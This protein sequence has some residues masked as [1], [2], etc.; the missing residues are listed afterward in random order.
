MTE[1]SADLK[2]ELKQLKKELKDLKQ[3]NKDLERLINSKSF[4]VSKKLATVFNNSFPLESKRREIILYAGKG[5]LS[6]S[7]KYQNRK[8]IAAQKSLRKVV[9]NNPVIIYDSIPWDVDLRQRPQHLAQQ[10]SRFNFFVVYLERGGTKTLRKVNDRLYTINHTSVLDG[11]K[12]TNGRK[13]FLASS[14]NVHSE[15]YE[16]VK[17]TFENNFG[18]IYEYIDD[19]SDDISPNVYELQMFYDSVKEHKPLLTLASSKKLR[20]NL[21]DDGFSEDNILLSENAAN[22]EH[23]DYTKIV[24]TVP[25]DLKKVLDTNRPVVGFYGAIAPWLDGN[26][27]NDLAKKRKDLE[28]VYVGPDYGGGKKDFK[29]YS[30]TH[31]LGAKNY[32]ELPNYGLYFDCAVIP[33]KPGDIAKST[34]PV[35]LF[36]YMAMGLPTVGTVDLV[37][38][39]GYDYVY[40]S[41]DATEFEN[42]IDRAIADKKDLAARKALL[43]QAKRNTWKQRAHDIVNYLNRSEV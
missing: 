39:L 17:N 30:N 42:N 38:L 6:A 3:R 11:L 35:K 1:K 41:K 9:G 16:T 36:E 13:I 14:T 26:L 32:E 12:D 29:K 20:Q 23:F 43:S 24:P 34:S 21:L 7:R 19:I 22:V 37:E 10:L 40:V 33:F 31:F 15:V 27:M 2:S 25:S 4:R 28:F 5:V 8:I 18:L